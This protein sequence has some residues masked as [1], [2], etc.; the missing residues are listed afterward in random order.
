VKY[1]PPEIQTEEELEQWALQFAYDQAI[2]HRS[3]YGRTYI[4]QRRITGRRELNDCEPDLPYIQ[5]GDKKVQS[6]FTS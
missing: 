1:P 3:V 2:V 5:I 6:L 4:T